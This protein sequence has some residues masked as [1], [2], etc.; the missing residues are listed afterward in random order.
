MRAPCEI[1]AQVGS[2]A[3]GQVSERLHAG[4][5][6]PTSGPLRLVG[7]RGR[8]LFF[9]EVELIDYIQAD[10]NY[11]SIRAGE[12]RYLARSTLKNLAL[13][14]APSGFVRITRSLLVNLHRVA[15]A[16]R[17]GGGSF[18]FTLRSG[19][20]LAST[21]TFRR[22]ILQEMHQEQPVAPAG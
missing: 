16:E 6:P 9:I 7:E 1:V 21:P 22:E 2:A 15:F 12:D 11:V 14:L 17:L 10:G 20:R 19:M 4:R 5:R 3:D 13:A 18:E 8:R